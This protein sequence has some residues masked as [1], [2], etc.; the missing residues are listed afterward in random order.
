MACPFYSAARFPRLEWLGKH[1][2]H[3]DSGGVLGGK[4][5]VVTLFELAGYAIK[6]FLRIPLLPMVPV[7]VRL[8]LL[9]MF[10]CSLVLPLSPSFGQHLYFDVYTRLARPPSVLSL[11][12][13]KTT[14]PHFPR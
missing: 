8:A 2:V 10:I 5:A 1:V 14:V 11:M 7:S 6:P 13:P 3:W 12:Y 9:K 4:S